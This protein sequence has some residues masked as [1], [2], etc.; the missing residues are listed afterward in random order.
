MTR[1]DIHPSPFS[2]RR[3]LRGAAIGTA[4]V[5]VI[6]V[7]ASGP[8]TVPTPSSADVS[9]LPGGEPATAESGSLKTSPSPLR[10]AVAAGSDRT[11]KDDANATVCSDRVSKAVHDMPEADQAKLMERI[12]QSL[13]ASSDERVRNAGLYLAATTQQTNAHS[14][15]LD[16]VSRECRSAAE[17]T[18]ACDKAQQS[19]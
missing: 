9:L 17:S 11:A 1:I 12:Y 13:A 4:V 5:L 18:P 6:L 10:S 16:E 19:L 2:W 3:V 7:P 15:A 14:S 8:R